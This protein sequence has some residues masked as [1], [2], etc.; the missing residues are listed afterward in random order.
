MNESQIG[1]MHGLSL[2]TG[3]D[4]GGDSGTGGEE[5]GC[6]GDNGGG[7][8]DAKDRWNDWTCEDRLR[9]ACAW[10]MGGWWIV[11][12]PADCT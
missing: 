10:T 6:G 1:A 4:S 5:S 7:S 8:G 12:R 9:V 3:A 11:K 2:L